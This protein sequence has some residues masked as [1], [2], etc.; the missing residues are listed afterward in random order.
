MEQKNEYKPWLVIYL[1]IMTIDIVLG[2]TVRMGVI[3]FIANHFIVMF[4][5]LIEQLRF[6]KF[7]KIVKFNVYAYRVNSWDYR[8]RLK[9]IIKLENLESEIESDILKFLFS[10]KMIILAGYVNFISFFVLARFIAI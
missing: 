2:V 8:R 5:Y 6:K 9:K 1:L 3:Y 4:A 7:L 10:T